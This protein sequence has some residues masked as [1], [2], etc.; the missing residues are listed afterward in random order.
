MW[1]RYQTFDT[2]GKANP[3][4]R[5]ILILK[6]EKFT[7]GIIGRIDRQKGQLNVLKAFNNLKNQ[8]P[9]AK[10]VYNRGGK[11]SVK[12]NNYLNEIMEYISE[13]NLLHKV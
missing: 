9:D 10:F 11:Q 4:C 7:F 2:H 1:S 12:K 6:R 5:E 8:F 13:N 3:E